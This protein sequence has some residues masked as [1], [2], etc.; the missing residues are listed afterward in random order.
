MHT[1][2]GGL[3]QE[4]PHNRPSVLALTSEG[5]TWLDGREYGPLVAVTSEALDAWTDG[6]PLSDEDAEAFVA[7][8]F[9]DAGDTGIVGAEDGSPRT[10]AD[11]TDWAVVTARYQGTFEGADG[12]PLLRYEDLEWR[13]AF[14]IDLNS[15]TPVLIDDGAG[16][17]LYR[18]GQGR[19]VIANDDV[20]MDATSE[21]AAE[22]VYEAAPTRRWENMPLLAE[23]AA[24][25]RDLADLCSY[26]EH[27]GT[28]DL[29]EGARQD[30][31]ARDAAAAHVQAVRVVADLTRTRVQADIR[32]GRRNA[33]RT[34]NRAYDGNTTHAAA[35]VAIRRQ[36]F[37][38]LIK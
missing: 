3:L 30:W 22:L 12:S 36:T 5:W 28:D 33:A 31:A 15:L 8:G 21:Q 25:A 38:D 18:T 2:T 14:W 16:W 17:R 23:A 11:D 6:E 37:L 35:A 1:I 29:D 7:Q 34:V 4:A 24:A 32:A 9:G 13:A 27:P 26:P 10:P 20:W 19:W